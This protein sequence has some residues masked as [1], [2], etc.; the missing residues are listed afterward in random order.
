MPLGRL[1]SAPSAGRPLASSVAAASDRMPAALA[2]SRGQG[3]GWASSRAAPVPAALCGRPRS[4]PLLA[5]G[6]SATH[7]AIV[8]PV[9]PPPSLGFPCHAHRDVWWRPV[10]MASCWQQE[11]S[12]QSSGRGS[13]HMST[14]SMTRGQK[15]Q[16]SQRR[17]QQQRRRRQRAAA[18]AASGWVAAAARRRQQAAAGGTTAAEV[19][20]AASACWI[21][22]LQPCRECDAS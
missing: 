1:W 16:S 21:V 2:H 18:W 10:L 19:E 13:R 14:R 9:S 17:P 5:P 11:A 8:R 20:L 22:L 4:P 6:A 15:R 7:A 3:G 12:M